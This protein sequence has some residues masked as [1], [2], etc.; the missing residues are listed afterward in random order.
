MF[1]FQVSA[2]SGR[3]DNYTS[4]LYRVKAKGVTQSSIPWSRSFVYKCLPHSKIRREAFKSDAL[5]RNEVA[6]YTKALP[7]LLSFQKSRGCNEFNDVPKVYLAMSN[8]L[9]LEDLKER[10]FVMADRKKGLDV[11]HCQAVVK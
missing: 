6:F 7:A 9:V 8:V 2:G 4:M 11:E 1:F 5:F 10:K 3:G